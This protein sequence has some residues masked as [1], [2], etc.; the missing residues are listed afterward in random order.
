MKHKKIYFCEF[1][2]FLFSYSGS[3]HAILEKLL[4]HHL[5]AVE[6]SKQQG[7]AKVGD[8]VRLLVLVSHDKCFQVI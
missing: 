5:Q 6:E 3:P 2:V 1:C 7:S 4:Q 8:C